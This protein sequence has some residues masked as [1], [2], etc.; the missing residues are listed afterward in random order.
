MYEPSFDWTDTLHMSTI[1]NTCHAVWRNI[2]FNDI[3][4]SYHG[5]YL[6]FESCWSCCW[7]CWCPKSSCPWRSAAVEKRKNQIRPWNKQIKCLVRYNGWDKYLHIFPTKEKQSI[8]LTW[9]TKFHQCKEVKVICTTLRELEAFDF[10]C[11]QSSFRKNIP[12][13]QSFSRPGKKSYDSY[14]AIS[15]SIDGCYWYFVKQ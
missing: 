15:N 9:I 6:V 11:N 13:W 5:T 2:I 3:M 1:A 8:S 10:P 14:E 4:S 7:C 12:A